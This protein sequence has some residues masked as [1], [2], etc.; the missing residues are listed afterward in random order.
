M[1]KKA[2]I[3][4]VLLLCFPLILLSAVGAAEKFPSKPIELV[5]PFAA[6]GSTDVLARLVAKYAPQHFDKPL[7]VINKPGGVESRAQKEW[8][9]PIR[10]GTPSM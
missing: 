9:G 10:M 5:V 3:I 1:G 2:M 7:V 8:C 4:W 6:G